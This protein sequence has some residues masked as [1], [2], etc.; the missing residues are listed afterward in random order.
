[1]FQLQAQ[2]GK[3]K[4]N[5]GTDYQ[6]SVCRYFGNGSEESDSNQDGPNVELDGFGSFLWSLGRY[7]A[8][9]KDDTILADYWPLIRDR[10]A[11]ALIAATEPYSGLVR[12]DSSIWEVHWN[13][14]QQQFAYSSLT[15]AAGL[16]AAGELADA[17]GEKDTARS[18]RN[19]ARRL[20]QAMTDRLVDSSN[21]IAAS[22][23]KKQLTQK[24]LDAAVVEAASMNLFDPKSNIVSSTLST[25]R[26]QL[27]VG[28]A[29]SGRGMFRNQ[30]GGSYDTQEWV[31]VDLR[32][33][34]ALRMSGANGDDLWTWVNAQS[35]A[36]QNVIA[37]LYD[38]SSADYAGSIPMIGFGAGAYLLAAHARYAMTPVWLPCGGYSNDL[39]SESVSGAT[40]GTGGSQ[41]KSGCQSADVGSVSLAFCGALLLLRGRRRT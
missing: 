8:L 39:E 11:G 1:V 20:R 3:Y 4:D 27:T 17:A 16:C 33:S 38:A 36:N 22:L 34:Q 10:I 21:V 24:Y 9:S 19:A 37:E 7:H 14:K 6:I 28:G 25:L 12:A 23:Q 29:G 5:V 40:G 31:F 30:D 35:A 32:M 13:G 18:Y 41:P 15:A 2:S 26:A